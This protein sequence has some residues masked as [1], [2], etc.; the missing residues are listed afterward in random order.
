M[1]GLIDGAGR[2]RELSTSLLFDQCR[3]RHQRELAACGLRRAEAERQ[4]CGCTRG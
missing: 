4:T 3:R 1:F 2:F